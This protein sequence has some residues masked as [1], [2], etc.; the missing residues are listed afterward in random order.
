MNNDS[1]KREIGDIRGFGFTYSGS[2]EVSSSAS[3]DEGVADVSMIVKGSKKF[4][5]LEVDLRKE[6]PGNWR[7]EDFRWPKLPSRLVSRETIGGSGN[8]RFFLKYQ[9]KS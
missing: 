8:Q 4:V 6:K 9:I 7:V 3:G 2:I 1:P 5:E